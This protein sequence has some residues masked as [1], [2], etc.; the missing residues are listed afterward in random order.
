MER[1]CPIPELSRWWYE[2][3]EVPGGAAGPERAMARSVDTAKAAGDHRERA[4]GRNVS[5]GCAAHT[6]NDGG[7]SE[8]RETREDGA[9]EARETREEPLSRSSRWEGSGKMGFKR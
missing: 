5:T 9:S 6:G 7:A 3:V 4:R 2:R 1:E 8:A